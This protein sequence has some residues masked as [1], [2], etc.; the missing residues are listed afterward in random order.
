[1]YRVGLH[2]V[3]EGLLANPVLFLEE[4]VLR[5]RPGDVSADD[6]L[7][8][9]LGLHVLGVLGLIL[10]FVSIAE[11]LPGNPAEVMRDSTTDQLLNYIGNER[12]RFLCK[13]FCRIN[14]FSRNPML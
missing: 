10:G 12:M 8:R 4:V 11:Q 5:I 3:E 2:D 13:Y 14:T 6:F 9:G 1:M 7:A